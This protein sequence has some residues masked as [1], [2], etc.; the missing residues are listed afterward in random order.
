MTNDSLVN[1]GFSE[2]WVAREAGR[3]LASR[4]LAEMAGKPKFFIVYSTIHYAENGGFKELLDGIYEFLPK[5]V[6][7]IGGT[8]TGLMI[9]QGCYSHGA[10]G[11]AVSYPNMDVSVC[12]G[13]NIKRDPTAAAKECAKKIKSDLSSSK[14]QNQFIFTFSAGT[15]ILDVPPVGRTSVVRSE[16]LAKTIMSS[17]S[18][19]QYVLQKG[20]GR[21]DDLLAALV[22]EIP[23]CKLLHGSAIDDVKMLRNYQF[24]NNTVLTNAVVC[25]GV[26]SDL[27]TAINFAHGAEP[28]ISFEITKV[29]DDGRIIHEINNK[30]AAEELLRLINWQEGF[31]D[32]KLFTKRFPFFPLGLHVNGKFFIRPFVMILGD[33][34]L[35]MT[36]VEKGKAFIARINGGSMVS[37]V[38]DALAASKIG[39]P[40]FGLFTSCAI[41]FMALGRE[42]YLERDVILKHLHSTPFLL[43]YCGGEAVYTPELGLGYLNE[44]IGYAV[45]GSD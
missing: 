6:P 21:E 28:S 29:S 38:D 15:E 37:S 39:A 33:S 25:L 7:L 20:S 27:N 14:F 32:E 42:I 5:D 8:V 34:I 41:R 36:K 11:M 31:F 24:Y 2:K 22:A 3:E 44:S 40:I 18:T 19:S 12:V 4:A 16:L 23:N 13:N 26:K 1:V 35:L 17:F 45:F 30:P 43:G 10:A 9:P